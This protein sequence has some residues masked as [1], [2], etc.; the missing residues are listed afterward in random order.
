MSMMNGYLEIWLLHPL[1][2][3]KRLCS[4]TTYIIIIMGSTMFLRCHGVPLEYM[5]NRHHVLEGRVPNTAI[6]HQL[7]QYNKYICGCLRYI[8]ILARHF[9]LPFHFS[10]SHYHFYFLFSSCFN[11]LS[12]HVTYH[13]RLVATANITF[14][15]EN[16]LLSFVAPLTFYSYVVCFILVPFDFS[17]SIQ[18][19]M[20]WELDHGTVIHIC[21]YIY[22]RQL[23]SVVRRRTFGGEIAR[24]HGLNIEFEKFHVDDEWT[25]ISW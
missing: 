8:A 4:A 3:E 17:L 6:I 25:S 9:L 15:P 11:N 19:Y 20:T 12:T 21:I 16:L 24:G 7:L 22:I 1:I 10:L 2:L 23:K 5:R 18:F 14:F 13:F